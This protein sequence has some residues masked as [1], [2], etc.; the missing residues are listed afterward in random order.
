MVDKILGGTD[1]A[2]DILFTLTEGIG[3]PLRPVD[4]SSGG[5]QTITVQTETIL[6]AV[7]TVTQQPGALNTPLQLTLGGAQ[8]NA[9]VD[10]SAAGA[11]TFLEADEYQVY[12]RLNIGRQGS[13]STA[14]MYSRALVNGVQYGSSVLSRIDS[15]ND[16]SPATFLFDI[17]PNVNDVLTFEIMRST[18]GTSA[19]GVFIGDPSLAGWAL[20][21]SV[22]VNI[23]RNV[24]IAS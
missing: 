2:T 23:S 24:A 3:K 18:Q 22:A 21:S 6:I 11:I 5:S 9:V 8:A 1:P 12:I 10:L 13:G 7:S 14:V 16:V 20:A 17:T 19:G 4:N 15:Q